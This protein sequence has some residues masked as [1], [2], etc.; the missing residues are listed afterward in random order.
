LHRHETW[1]LKRI[2]KSKAEVAEMKF[3][4][5]VAGYIPLLA[6]NYLKIFNKAGKINDRKMKGTTRFKNE[7]TQGI[8]RSCD[9]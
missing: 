6:T 9:L 1:A 8:S 4:W 2:N 7:F 3:F 5:R